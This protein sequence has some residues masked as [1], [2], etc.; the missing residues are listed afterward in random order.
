MLSEF[1]RLVGEIFPSVDSK[2]VQEC[3]DAVKLEDAHKSGPRFGKSLR[4]SGKLYSTRPPAK[5]LQGDVV[6]PVIFVVETVNGELLERESAAM[7]LSHS[8]DLD[9]D[10]VAVVAEC[11]PLSAYAGDPKLPAIVNNHVYSKFY[12]PSVPSDG[13]HYVVDLAQPL[14]V[15]VD[16]LWAAYRAGHVRRV[17]SLSQLGY[18]LFVAKLAI[19][20]LRPQD[21]SDVRELVGAAPREM[22]RV[23]ERMRGA[24]SRIPAAVRYIVNG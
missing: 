17:A 24:W 19:H 21:A 23:R 5:L 8:C 18:W 4:T 3:L 13:E 12:L 10:V 1:A 16:K 15:R 11:R 2:T 7:I 20:F 6:Y 14:Q 22:R 9:N